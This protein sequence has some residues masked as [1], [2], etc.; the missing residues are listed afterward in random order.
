MS[1]G[2]GKWGECDGICQKMATKVGSV[3]DIDKRGGE[4]YNADI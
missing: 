3:P 2:A 4:Y 1:S